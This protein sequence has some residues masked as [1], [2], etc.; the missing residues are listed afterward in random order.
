MYTPTNA[1]QRKISSGTLLA[2]LAISGVFVFM[3]IV[4][5]AHATNA[6]PPTLK[7]SPGFNY[8]IA[9]STDT[10]FWLTITNP[11]TNTLAINTVSITFPSGW[12]NAFSDACDWYD[13]VWGS[14]SGGTSSLTWSVS[15]SSPGTGLVPGASST[16]EFE[17]LNVPA[18]SGTP[19][20][21][22]FTTSIGD[23]NGIFSTGPSFSL[24]TFNSAVTHI[25][26]STSGGGGTFPIAFTAGSGSITVSAQLAGAGDAPVAASGV[27]II[28]FVSGNPGSFSGSGVT[29]TTIFSSSD[30]CWALTNSAGKATVTMNPSNTDGVGTV[31]ASQGLALTA[32]DSD[33]CTPTS[34]SV[35]GGLS[36]LCEEG[37]HFV[38][39][40]TVTTTPGAPTSVLF[41][42]AGGDTPF[43]TSATHFVTTSAAVPNGGLG[44]VMAQIAAS[45]LTV[46]A[47]DHFGNPVTTG[48]TGI[49]VSTTSAGGL[50]STGAANKT[51]ID[52][53]G[54]ITCA[55][56]TITYAYYQSGTY[57]SVGVLSATVT[58]SS[59]TVSGSSG[60][61]VT[62]TF[63][64]T[65]VIPTFASGLVSP[66]AAGSVV[67][68]HVS[69]TPHQK[70]V[71]VTVYLDTATSTM[72]NSD[73]TMSVMANTAN[74]GTATMN[75]NLDTGKD[76]T[77]FYV[78]NYA[79][80]QDSGAQ[81]VGNSSDSAAMATVAG[82]AA[83]LV[84]NT[85]YDSA[86]TMKA[87][88]AVNTAGTTLYVDVSLADKYG[89]PTSNTFT[90]QIQITLSGPG[91][92]SATSVY[93][94]SGKADTAT[95]FGP[96]LWHTP[97]ALGAATLTATSI[98][99][100]A[101]KAV[102]IVSAL[103]TLSV[104]SPTPLNGVIYSSSTAVTFLGQANA[105]VGY[106]STANIA[107][108]GYKIDSGA[109]QTAATTTANKVSWAISVSLAAG[110]H[111]VQFNAT[112]DQVPST[113]VSQVYTVLVDTAAPDVNFV[114]PNNANLS[115]GAT[116]AASI[117]DKLGDLNGSSV[118]AVGNSTTALTVA[119][120]GTN[121]PGHSVSY[122]VTISGLSAGT[123]SIELSASDLAGN[124]NSSTITVNVSVP[125]G[126]TFT[127]TGAHSSSS[128]GFTGAA[129][130]FTNNGVSSQTVNVYFVWYN[131]ANQVV[132]VGAQ[133]NVAF[134]KGE[135]QTFF[136]S[137][138]TPG[139]YTVKVFVQDSSG[140][141]LSPSYSATVTVT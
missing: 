140:N 53:T 59:F 54:G 52:C 123:W 66:M 42:L 128:G 33:A 62:S 8:I 102:T 83:K 4:G 91:S 17:D 72:V 23:S 63:D 112:D 19:A 9:G 29:C 85:Y 134:A 61:I 1:Y 122:S 10:G 100:T 135:S 14:C 107:S 3:P 138:N 110:S 47:A 96:I 26:L 18:W 65:A 101:T 71:P 49:S 75:F 69:L 31:W 13:S 95:S 94:A 88:H 99:P 11:S 45:T 57:G 127:S 130:T 43:P 5:S 46:S 139:T 60:T 30:T 64:S 36:W 126:Q 133:L 50:F 113:V 70:G 27:P 109:W 2:L 32:E 81:T 116:V 114:T 115:G 40:G 84:V 55:S 7:I 86:L 38:A 136:N 73:G 35:A 21:G 79:R 80:P 12:T 98:F 6:S 129:A 20:T 141:A 58:G 78:S 76:A 124:S 90:Y 56:G 104:T 44:N 82:P 41:S 77:L 108:V 28:F 15:G 97:T 51:T 131:S 89:N 39:S 48:I 120:V 22:T 106:P 67:Q 37:P 93:I 117:V 34:S 118:A 103:P 132:S 92:L 25:D 74:N 111:T 137:Y 87:S 68:L 24:H 125:V 121:N 105:S 16:L 119:V